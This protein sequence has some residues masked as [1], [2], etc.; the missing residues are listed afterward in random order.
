MLKTRFERTLAFLVGATA[1]VAALLATLQLDAGRK[2]NRATFLSAR[3]PVRIFEDIA[4]SGLRG[5]FHL[6]TGR[7]A[8][9]VALQA[10]TRELTVLKRHDPAL[11]FE[12]ALGKSDFDASKH[13]A[14]AA[15][16]MAAI[17]PASRGVDPA[18]QAA[19]LATIPQE[20]TLVAKQGHQVDLS[21]T[22]G[23]EQNRSVFALT[24]VAIAAALLGLAAVLRAGPGGRIALV[25][26]TIA[27]LLSVAWGALAL[28][29]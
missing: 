15:K 13:I 29:G 18:T 2:S 4:A 3:L 24:L 11:A 26:G 9:A 23:T 12:L 27:L 20:R 8:S 1:L 25:A 10:L 7:E 22:Y 21:N 17:S 5:D 6:N 16:E 19:I 28:A 14:A